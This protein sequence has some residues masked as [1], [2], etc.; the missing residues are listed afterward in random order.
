[1]SPSAFLV[2]DQQPISLNQALGYLQVSGH[3]QPFLLEILYQ[4]IL[5]QAVKS[6]VSLSSVELEQRLIEFRLDYQLIDTNEF[7]QWLS[8]CDTDYETFRQQFLWEISVEALKDQICQPQLQAVFL[9]RKS[10]FDQVVLSWIGVNTEAE[11]QSLSQ[12]LAAGIEFEQLAAECLRSAEADISQRLQQ[13]D[14]TALSEVLT[15][16]ELPE[17]LQEV[18]QEAQLEAV[19]GPMAIDDHWYLVRLE[20][21]LPAE[22]N[23]ELKEHL[24]NEIFDQWLTQKVEALTVQLSVN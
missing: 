19:M 5:V 13:D 9:Q 4:H 16:E 3:L 15:W 20:E 18:I 24:T 23:D 22:L 1:M 10:S 21:W 14:L 17:E 7:Q 11:A 8:D 2:I 12:Q 6:Q